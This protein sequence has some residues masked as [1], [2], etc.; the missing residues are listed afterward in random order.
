MAIKAGELLPGLAGPESL[1]AT[2]SQFL[3]ADLCAP[4]RT[5]GH[6]VASVVGSGGPARGPTAPLK[7]RLTFQWLTYYLR[8]GTTL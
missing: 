4:E 2:F 1:A 6:V 8:Y 3:F 7:P 5:A